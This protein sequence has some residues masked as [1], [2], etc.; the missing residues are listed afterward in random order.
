MVS[1][2]WFIIIIIRRKRKLKGE[3]KEKSV[4]EGFAVN[5]CEFAFTLPP[6]YCRYI[7]LGGESVWTK[8]YNIIIREKLEKVCNYT[9]KL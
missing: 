3:K 6:F 9:I 8:E 2:K 7:Y 5:I 4:H 1:N